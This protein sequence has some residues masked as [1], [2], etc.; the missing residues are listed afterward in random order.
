MAI[1][2]AVF[3]WAPLRFARWVLRNFDR[4]V[5]AAW[6]N[7]LAIDRRDSFLLS[8]IS[9]RFGPICRR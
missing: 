6:T 5:I 2:I 1:L 7:R 4:E 8:P 3:G 9:N